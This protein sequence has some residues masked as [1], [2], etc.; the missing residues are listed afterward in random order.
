MQ[1]VL[2]LVKG[3]IFTHGLKHYLEQWKFL[4]KKLPVAEISFAEIRSLD[5]ALVILDLPASIDGAGVLGELLRKDHQ[6]PLLLL[7]TD[8]KLLKRHWLLLGKLKHHDCLPKP[9]PVAEIKRAVEGL[10]GCSLPVLPGMAAALEEV[11]PP[12]GWR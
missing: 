4:V 2:L 5:R 9:C 11:I 6:V 3:E 7:V 12:P 10:L 8:I 1:T